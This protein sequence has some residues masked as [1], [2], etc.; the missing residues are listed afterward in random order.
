MQKIISLHGLENISQTVHSYIFRHHSCGSTTF[1]KVNGGA[2]FGMNSPV[3]AI[4]VDLTVQW[5][6]GDDPGGGA[7]PLKRIGSFH[8]FLDL[9]TRS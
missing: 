2:R 5:F 6:S 8:T 9:F 3:T 7:P 4:V 1:C